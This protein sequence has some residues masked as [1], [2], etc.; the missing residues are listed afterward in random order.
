MLVWIRDATV[1][2][3]D[4][5]VKVLARSQERLTCHIPGKNSSPELHR[6][7]TR[8]KLPICSSYCKRRRKCGK[9]TFITRCRFE[10]LRQFCENTKLNPVEDSLKSLN[11]IY[12]LT[13]TDSEVR[14]NDSN[15]F[16][17]MLWKAN[18]DIQFV[19]ESSLVLAHYVSGHVMKAER[20]NMQ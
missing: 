10:F 5:P 1:I 15:L 2:G 6:L 20:S 19:A 13:R 11:K 3:Q 14:V 9:H 16:L 12:Q 18:V 17:L 4:D 8:Y 7:V